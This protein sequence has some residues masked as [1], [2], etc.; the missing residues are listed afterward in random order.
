MIPIYTL[1]LAL[2]ALAAAENRVFRTIGNAACQLCLGDVESACKGPVSSD[3]FNDCFC[4]A[5]GPAWDVFTDCLLVKPDCGEDQ[6]QILGAFG[7]HCFANKDDEEEEFCVDGS[8]GDELKLSVADMFCT[9][10][11]TLSTSSSVQATT[12]TTS[13]IETSR[14]ITTTTSKTTISTTTSS[15]SFEAS[16]TTAISTSTGA[17]PTSTTTSSTSNTVDAAAATSATDGQAKDSDDSAGSS[18]SPI[19]A[20]GAVLLV[21]WTSA[22]VEQVL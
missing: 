4:A 5:D 20:L 16:A 3:Q 14:K 9:E 6:Y 10:F 13:P 21:L 18:L 11:I 15:K 19:G 17:T 8:Q 7:A 12:T 22:L 2:T 1:A